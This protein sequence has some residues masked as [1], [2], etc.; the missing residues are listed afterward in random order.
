MADQPTLAA[1]SARNGARG[2]EAFLWARLWML[3]V[4][5]LV[6]GVREA[7]IWTLIGL[8]ALTAEEGARVGRHHA[9]VDRKCHE[10]SDGHLDARVLHRLVDAVRRRARYLS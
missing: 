9:Q 1:D 5:E 6:R 4:D 7:G 8:G 2:T 3:T 10:Q